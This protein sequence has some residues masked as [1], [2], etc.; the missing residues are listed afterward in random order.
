MTIE[1]FVSVK[2]GKNLLCIYGRRTEIPSK[3][4]AGSSP[5]SLLLL[6]HRS[7][8][9]TRTGWENGIGKGDEWGTDRRSAEEKG[10]NKG[11]IIGPLGHIVDVMYLTW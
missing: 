6:A 1:N 8:L 5:P 3:N 2:N 10:R 4:I 7:G 11:G 9:W